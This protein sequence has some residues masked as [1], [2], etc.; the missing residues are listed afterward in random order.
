M[1]YTPKHCKPYSAIRELNC[2]RRTP[3]RRKGGLIDRLGAAAFTIDDVRDILTVPDE[4][5]EMGKR[6]PEGIR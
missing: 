2:A 4:I 6:L 3:R 5:R 1:T